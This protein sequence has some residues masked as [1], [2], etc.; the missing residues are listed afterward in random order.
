MPPTDNKLLR[1]AIN[2]AH[3][4][5]ALHRYGDEGFHGGAAGTAVG[6]VVHPAF[7][8]EKNKAYAFD[9]DKAKS[10]VANPAQQYRVQ[11]FMVAGGLRGRIRGIGHDHPG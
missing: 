6:Q 7:D 10:L 5:Q 4:S 8:A 3:R 1:Q 2:Y 9:L 11:R